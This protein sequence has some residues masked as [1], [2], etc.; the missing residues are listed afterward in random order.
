MK[1]HPLLESYGKWITFWMDKVSGSV[2]GTAE[3][4]VENVLETFPAP[5]PQKF[6]RNP[7]LFAK[8]LRSALAKSLIKRSPMQR[9]NFYSKFEKSVKQLLG[10]MS[11]LVQAMTTVAHMGEKWEDGRGVRKFILSSTPSHVTVLEKGRT[12][13]Y[14]P[15]V[16]AKWEKVGDAPRVRGIWTKQY[17]KPVL[18]RLD[19]STRKELMRSAKALSLDHV[20]SVLS[21][22]SDEEF[23]ALVG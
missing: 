6:G 11:S 7:Q 1:S 21:S 3:Q 20:V 16:V 19:G 10:L 12:K 8:T 4:F 17:L 14:A 18:R 13:D 5:D 23:K 15:N 22:V 9:T 2:E